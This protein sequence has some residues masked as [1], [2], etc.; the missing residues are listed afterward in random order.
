[1]EE[2]WREVVG[3][4]NYL[5]SNY[6]EIFSVDQDRKLTPTVMSGYYRVPLTDWSGTR[7]VYLHQLV[8]TAFFPSFRDGTRVKHI[9]GNNLD[10]S[11]SNL[12][13]LSYVDADTNRTLRHMPWGKRILVVELQMIFRTARDCANYIGGD[14]S[15]IYACLRGDRNRHMGYTFEYFEDVDFA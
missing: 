5:V 2:E 3:Y 8:A 14:Y 1:M 11:V 13:P 12:L 4:P 15:S 9:N 10:N 6:G 7:R